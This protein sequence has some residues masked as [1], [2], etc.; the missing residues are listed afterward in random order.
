LSGHQKKKP[1]LAPGLPLDPGTRRQRK[2]VTAVLAQAHRVA[3]CQMIVEA[4][5]ERD[6]EVLLLSMRIARRLVADDRGR[7]LDAEGDQAG[8]G[9]RHGK[10]RGLPESSGACAPQETLRQQTLTQW[11]RS[12]PFEPRRIPPLDEGTAECR[13]VERV[14]VGMCSLCPAGLHSRRVRH[15]HDRGIRFFPTFMTGAVPKLE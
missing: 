4:A 2:S 7:D 10:R 9:P 15:R 3:V 8:R 1:G 5:R 14:A 11:S 6:G 13:A 12:P